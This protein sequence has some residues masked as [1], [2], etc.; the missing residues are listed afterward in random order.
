[1]SLWKT[2]ILRD[3]NGKHSV[4]VHM[5]VYVPVCQCACTCVCANYPDA[6][7]PGHAQL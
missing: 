3:G 5:C 4:H 2:I 7:A 6:C 1:M